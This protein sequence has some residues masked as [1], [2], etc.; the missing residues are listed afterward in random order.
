MLNHQVTVDTAGVSATTHSTG[1]N[2]FDASDDEQGTSNKKIAA[3]EKDN[4]RRL[5]VNFIGQHQSFQLKK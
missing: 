3:G 2:I 1:S 4:P 5:I